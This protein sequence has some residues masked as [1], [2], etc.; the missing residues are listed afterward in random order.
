VTPRTVDAHDLPERSFELVSVGRAFPFYAN[1]AETLVSL[2]ARLVSA[3]DR[4]YAE[5]RFDVASKIPWRPFGCIPAGQPSSLP[6]YHLA[7]RIDDG[8]APVALRDVGRERRQESLN[9]RRSTVRGQGGGSSCWAIAWRERMGVE[10][11][12][13]RRA[14]RHSF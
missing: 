4:I 11:T 10:P 5:R 7:S 9:G 1:G 8:I 13:R 2:G 14:P 3:L 12:A 6:G